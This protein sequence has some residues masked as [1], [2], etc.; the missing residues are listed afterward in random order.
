MFADPFEPFHEIVAEAKEEREQLDR[1][2][3]VTTPRERL[4]VAACG[5]TLL[6]LAGWLFLG[7]VTRS[8]ALD[9][10]LVAAAGDPAATG[11]TVQAMIW[12]ERDIAQKLEPGMTTA[13][14]LSGVNGEGLRVV[15]EIASIA[16]VTDSGGMQWQ[17]AAAPAAMHRL[18]ISLGEDI[19]ESTVDGS[20]CRI[21]VTLGEYSPVSLLGPGRT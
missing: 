11:R 20:E 7:S 2:L 16:A 9:G 10:V 15:G 17:S 3:T 1:L 8:V 21:V 19:S 5:L 4:L 12:L 13:L 18:G 6:A 14:E